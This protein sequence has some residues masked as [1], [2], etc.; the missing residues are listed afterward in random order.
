MPQFYTCRT[1][2]NK[3]VCFH[4]YSCLVLVMA[5][6]KQI[7]KYRE[8]HG[9]TLEQLSIRSLVDLGTISALENR[10]SK[11]SEKAPAIA[12]ALGLSVEQLLDEETDW[13]SV[14][15]T[16]VTSS[17]VANKTQEP[18]PRPP[19]VTAGNNQL[20]WPFSVSQEK[21]MRLLSEDDVR[22]IDTYIKGIIS[23]REIDQRKRDAA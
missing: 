7:K 13:F 8:Q 22:N 23:T 18:H 17:E 15:A 20:Y 9:W 6:G 5:L 12:K 10:D 16:Y 21:F 3:C 19:D 11:R 1:K 4:F 2:F 14:A